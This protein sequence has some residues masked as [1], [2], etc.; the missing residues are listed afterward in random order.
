MLLSV[1]LLLAVALPA[2]MATPV[3][4]GVQFANRGGTTNS[5]G[6]EFTITLTGGSG[7]TLDSLQIS[8]TGDL[9]FDPAADYGVDEYFDG[10]TDPTWTSPL[11]G[12]KGSFP[13]TATFNFG[14]FNPG[15]SVMIT[16]DVDDDGGITS[17][18]LPSGMAGS[19][20]EL[21][22][23]TIPSLYFYTGP[24]SAV[25]DSNGYAQIVADVSY[26]P[27]RIPEPATTV[28][29]GFGLVALSLIG[30]RRFASKRD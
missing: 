5:I 16:L 2:A 23:L 12:Q 24:T 10:G 3:T 8:L 27:S 25:F 21:L 29:V 4:I 28:L 17:G 13:T 6:G 11:A 26:D 15:D 22:G 20:I 9:V 30:R 1:A 19:T 18:V 14:S 7:I